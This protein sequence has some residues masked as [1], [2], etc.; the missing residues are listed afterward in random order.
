[1]GKKYIYI[2]Y[3]VPKEHEEKASGLSV[4]GNKMQLSIVHELS[5]YDD[6]EL[7]PI[8][9]Y[10]CAS[11]PRD[12]HLIYK[13]AKIKLFDSCIALQVRFVNLPMLKQLCQ[14]LEVF[15]NVKKMVKENPDIELLTFNMYPQV[16]SPSCWIK[17]IYRNRITS[18]VADLPIDIKEDRSFFSRI[19]MNKFNAITKKNLEEVDKA[20]VLNENA[21]LQYLNT[22]EY[23]VVEG[24]IDVSELE[25]D[26]L[27]IAN[28]E[29]RDRII[30]YSGALTEYNGIRNLI[31]AMQLVQEDVV[32]R[33]YGDGPLRE[34]VESAAIKG[35][36]IEYMGSVSNDQML[37]LQRTAYLLINPRPIND[38]ISQVTFPS[39][40][41]EY[42]LSGTVILTTRLS[43]FT[44][45][46][47]DKMKFMGDDP[48]SMARAIDDCMKISYENMSNMAVKAREFAINR[49]SWAKQVKRIHDFLIES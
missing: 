5:K 27:H 18:I 44:V 14:I 39:K 36:K 47:L 46:Y 26:D 1:M 11:Y 42:L 15:C 28:Y 45:D 48:Y 9:I 17:K 16:G 24:G 3:C 40:I 30:I 8:T 4:A 43:G 32:L 20:I 21:K 33:I 49:K 37:Q 12:K 10:P 29:N 2:G 22:N 35:K 25:D 19:I 41:F 38:P 23:I 31:D 34:V 6:I 13:E 7:Y